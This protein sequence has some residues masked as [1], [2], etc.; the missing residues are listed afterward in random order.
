MEKPETTL[1]FDLVERAKADERGLVVACET[2]QNAKKFFDGKQLW[3]LQDIG[4][5][6]RFSVMGTCRISSQPTVQHSVEGSS[7]SLRLG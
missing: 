6:H 2:K 4:A 1:R 5:F 3:N 7:H